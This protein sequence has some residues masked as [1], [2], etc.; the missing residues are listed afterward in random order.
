MLRQKR[1]VLVAIAVLAVLVSLCVVTPR[2][3]RCLGYSNFVAKYGPVLAVEPTHLVLEQPPCEHVVDLGYASFRIPAHWEY[4]IE[5][6]GSMVGVEFDDK[7][8]GFLLPYNQQD[9]ESLKRDSIKG[10]RKQLELSED[11]GVPVTG[12]GQSPESWEDLESHDQAVGLIREM[13]S[14][15]FAWHLKVA[16]TPRH[17]LGTVFCMSK[18][19]F[20]RY[21]LLAAAK[22]NNRFNEN[23][24]AVFQT[25]FTQGL[26]RC[27]PSQ[28]PRE[29][30][31]EVWSKDGNISQAILIRSSSPLECPGAMGTILASY[32]FKITTVPPDNELEDLVLSALRTNTNFA[33]QE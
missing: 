2:A 1:L 12:L 30:M 26:L 11:L 32:K 3:W 19:D 4:S 9:Y 7:S 28:E 16:S 18:D 6:S 29:M 24:I 33:V 5:N 23:G 8:L 15:S 25:E 27:G 10:S 17:S 13:T 14:D 21:L 31:A 22:V 20:D